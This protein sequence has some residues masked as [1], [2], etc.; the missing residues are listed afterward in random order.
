LTGSGR[1]DYSSAI[2]ALSGIGFGTPEM[3]GARSNDAFDLERTSI[4]SDLLAQS[5]WEVC[6]EMVAALDLRSK[7]GT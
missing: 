4:Q 7:L 6:D 2:S 3:A 1:G 5:V